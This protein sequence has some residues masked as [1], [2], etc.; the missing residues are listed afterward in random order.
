M[1]LRRWVVSRREWLRALS[2]LASSIVTGFGYMFVFVV[3]LFFVL[4]SFAGFGVLG[5]PAVMGLVRRL[6]RRDRVKWG[7]YLGTPIN[8]AYRPVEGSLLGRAGTILADPA[9]RRDLGWIG[10]HLSAGLAMSIFG[11]GLL[12]GALNALTIPFYW[13]AL[14]ENEPADS[15][16][17]ITSWPRA[18]AMIPIGLAYLAIALVLVPKLANA[19]ARLAKL[20]LSP[21]KGAQLS[22]RVAELT[23]TRAAALEAHGNE[24]RRIERD[25]HDGTQNRIVAVVMQLGIAERALRRDPE[26]ALPMV[27]RAQDAATD[28]LAE[29]REVVRSIYPPILTERGLDGAA[30][31]LVARCPIP[32]TLEEG[33]VP[34]APAAVESAAYFVIAE[35]LTNVA[36]H[37]GATQASVRLDSSDVGMLITVTDDGHGGAVE[38]AGSGL[39]GIRRRVEAFDGVFSLV[40]PSGGPTTLTVELPCGS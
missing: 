10:V 27:L 1:D 29:L 17:E 3:A 2:Y 11:I 21:A 25:L 23:A 37:S 35:A 15:F 13:W 39:A 22:A 7:R 40:S 20:L 9:T 36:K 8:E 24:L 31:A 6:M 14:P 26:N 18:L 4:T 12:L 28:A 32:C 16:F 19:H 38:S 34:R 30:A 5:L 33:L